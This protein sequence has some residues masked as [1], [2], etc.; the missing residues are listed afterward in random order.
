M[1]F[2]LDNNII[3]QINN[4]LASHK[5]IEQAIIYGSRAMGTYRN[6][7]DIDLTLK[8]DNINLSTL[9]KINN[10]IDDLLTPYIFDISVFN[11]IKNKNLIEHITQVGKIFYQKQ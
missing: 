8:G 10:E 3:Q 11:N 5:Q 7:S 6:G 2:G 9:N 4:I 1:S